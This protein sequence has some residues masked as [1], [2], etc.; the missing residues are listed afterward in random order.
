MSKNRIPEVPANV[1][2]FVEEWRDLPKPIE[3]M[4]LEELKMLVLSDVVYSTCKMM[5]ITICRGEDTVSEN[6]LDTMRTFSSDCVV[7][8]IYL[9]DF[10]FSE[11]EIADIL[12]FIHEI[13]QQ[14]SIW[15]YPNSVGDYLENSEHLSSYLA[16][17]K[18][19]DRPNSLLHK[20]PIPEND[21]RIIDAQRIAVI[22]G[23]YQLLKQK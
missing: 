10:G 23:Q 21:G 9:N 1:V 2:E 12:L 7:T 3:E 13:K 16:A 4:S 22:S 17:I 15:P 19:K 6:Q 5:E 14:A 20:M 18:A 11:E 8:K